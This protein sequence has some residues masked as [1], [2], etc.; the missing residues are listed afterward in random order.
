MKTGSI[1]EEEITVLN[2]CV[3][4]NKP[5]KYMKQNLIEL[6]G[7]TDKLTITLGDINILLSN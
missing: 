1:H 7:E 2:V 6:K 5:S 3:S 4:N